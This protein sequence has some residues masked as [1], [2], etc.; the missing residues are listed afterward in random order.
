MHLITITGINTM[1]LRSLIL[2]AGLFVLAPAHGAELM[3]LPE[4]RAVQRQYVPPYLTEFRN[5]I[6]REPC[7]ELVNIR[8]GLL[9]RL[10]KARN[11]KDSEYY[12]NFLRILDKE[13]QARPG[14]ECGYE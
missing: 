2:L 9:E 11:P 7:A 3:P 12:M 1:A 5:K 6:Q 13:I 14:T 10:K 4:D 8:K